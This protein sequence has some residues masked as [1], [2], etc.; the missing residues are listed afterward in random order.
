MGEPG[1]GG[2]AVKPPR[3]DH[4]RQRSRPDHEAFAAGTH[5]VK[6]EIENCNSFEIKDRRRAASF[7]TFMLFVSQIIC[8]SNFV[9][10]ELR[11]FKNHEDSSGFDNFRTN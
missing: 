9:K 5:V 4:D 6:S 8:I 7:L 3:G 2:G 1:V 10:S 11:M